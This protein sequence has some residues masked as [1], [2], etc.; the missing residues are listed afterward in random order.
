MSSFASR[1]SILL[2]FKA[3]LDQTILIQYFKIKIQIFKTYMEN[4]LLKLQFLIC[5]EYLGAE[6]VQWW[7]VDLFLLPIQAG[8]DNSVH[9][10]LR[11]RSI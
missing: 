4:T 1:Q 3:K 2:V 7:Y 6:V 10:S 9:Q 8:S 11:S 5:D